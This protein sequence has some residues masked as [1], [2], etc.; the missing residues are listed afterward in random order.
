MTV[1]GGPQSISKLLR[2]SL[3]PA[4]PIPCSY[5]N[6]LYTVLTGEVGNFMFLSGIN[7]TQ[8]NLRSEKLPIFNWLKMKNGIMLDWLIVVTFLRKNL[9]FKKP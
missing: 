9:N 7:F 1:Y 6:G 4:A 8:D 2:G 5:A 3:T